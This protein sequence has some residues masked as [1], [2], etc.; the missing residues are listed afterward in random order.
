[1]ART[2]DIQKN[3]DLITSEESSRQTTSI[4]PSRHGQDNKKARLNLNELARISK[5][6]YAQQIRESTCHFPEK[7]TTFNF[8]GGLSVAQQA[9]V[10][11]SSSSSRH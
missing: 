4:E 10:Q 1:M 5:G 7:L 11:A 9:Q 3:I 6:D 8:V 2:E